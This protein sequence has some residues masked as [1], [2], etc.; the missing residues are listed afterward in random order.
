MRSGKKANNKVLIP[1]NFIHNQTQLSTFSSSTPFKPDESDKDKSA[2][3]VY[4]LIVSFPNRLKNNKQ[5]G[6][7][8]KI[9]EIFNQVKI[10]VPLLDAI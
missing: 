1:P 6:H 2:D 5:N 3:Q 9:I 7:M 8:D 10:N 4:I